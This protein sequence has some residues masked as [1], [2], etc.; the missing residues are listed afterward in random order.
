MKPNVF[1]YS[2]LTVGIVAAMGS[3]GIA[4]AA[5]PAPTTTDNVFSVVNQ[6]TASYTVAGNATEQTA[7]SNKVTVK[8]S[9]TASFTLGTSNGDVNEDSKINPQAG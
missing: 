4:N 8:V 3:A 1:K 7:T 9:E 2:V 5:G 6:A